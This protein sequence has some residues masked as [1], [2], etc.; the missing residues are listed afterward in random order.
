MELEAAPPRR[1]WFRELAGIF[2]AC[3]VLYVGY[4]HFVHRSPSDNSSEVAAQSGALSC[5][6]SDYYLQSRLDGSKE[7]IYDCQFPRRMRC[8]SEQ[9]GVT[10]DITEEVRLL[11]SSTLGASKPNCIS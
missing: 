2:V 3:L 1:H 8:V 10:S 7:T 5:S 11:F 6:R 9:G 4:Q